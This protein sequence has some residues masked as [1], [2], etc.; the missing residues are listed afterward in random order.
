M[1]KLVFA[2]VLLIVLII[3]AVAIRHKHKSF[4][5]SFNK[6]GSKSNLVFA[7]FA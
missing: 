2:I 5:E 4:L 6:S 1:I 3:I 7:G